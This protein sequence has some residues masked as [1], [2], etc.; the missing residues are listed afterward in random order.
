MLPLGGLAQPTIRKLI[1]SEERDNHRPQHS[2][3]PDSTHTHTLTR[4][5]DFSI[6]NHYSS[7]VSLPHPTSTQSRTRPLFRRLRN[8]PPLFKA[9]GVVGSHLLTAPLTRSRY[10]QR[11]FCA[12]HSA[13]TNLVAI[14]EILFGRRLSKATRTKVSL[15]SAAAGLANPPHLKCFHI[16]YRSFSQASDVNSVEGVSIDRDS[17]AWPQNN[18][19]TRQH[20][21]RSQENGHRD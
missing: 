13:S 5:P 9:T 12:V 10:S 4:Q 17:H 16:T 18:L 3:R 19:R 6:R 2:H 11:K 21:R 20:R 15:P 14:S 1:A 8:P 7:T